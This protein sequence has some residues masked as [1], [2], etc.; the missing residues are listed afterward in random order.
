M[1]KRES[2]DDSSVL[3]VERTHQHV[4]HRDVLKR[5]HLMEYLMHLKILRERF[6]YWGE[7][8]G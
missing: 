2:Q 5:L 4:P 1:G 3:G 6:N 7:G 8:W